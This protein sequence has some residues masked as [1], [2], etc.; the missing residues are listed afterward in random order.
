VRLVGP[1]TEQEMVLAFLCAEVDSPRYRAH[2]RDL[3]RRLIDHPDLTDADQNLARLVALD[4]R[5]RRLRIGLFDGFPPDVIWQRWAMTPTELGG[6][7][8]PDYP[9]WVRLSGGTRLVRDGAANVDRIEVPEDGRTL[10]VSVLAIA[11][12][13]DAGKVSDALICAAIDDAGA[14]IVLIEGHARA[15]AYLVAKAPPTEVEVLVGWSAGMANWRW[16]GP[17]GAQR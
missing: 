4:Y 6:V 2:F 1:A 17:H 14:G 16:Y 9:T 10:N 15:T 3:D 11:V 7:H 13:I 8:Y 12:A 5:G